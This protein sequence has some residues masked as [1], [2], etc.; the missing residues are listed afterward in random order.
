MEGEGC[1]VHLL[2][3]H[4]GVLAHVERV[5]AVVSRGAGSLALEGLDDRRG[6]MTR[7]QSA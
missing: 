7:S 1:G 6:P 5:K 3:R 4:L 2:E